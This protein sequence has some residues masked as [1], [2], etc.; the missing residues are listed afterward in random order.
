MEVIVSPKRWSPPTRLQYGVII[1]KTSVQ[2]FTSVEPQML[3]T[4]TILKR[5][6]WTDCPTVC[7]I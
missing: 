4:I 1:Q 2:I 3:L 7:A 6:N 5:Y